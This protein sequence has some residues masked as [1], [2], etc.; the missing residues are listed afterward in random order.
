[1]YR[2]QVVDEDVLDKPG[3]TGIATSEKQVAL[4]TQHSIEVYEVLREG[5]IQLRLLQE[6]KLD[7]PCTGIHYFE[8][9][10]FSFAQNQIVAGE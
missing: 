9:R 2:Y 1:M 8:E 3:V 6:I 5:L 4:L 10:L 7:Q